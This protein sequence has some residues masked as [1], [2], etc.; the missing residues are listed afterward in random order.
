M[1]FS[2]QSILTLY[3]QLFEKKMKY[4]KRVNAN[5]EKCVKIL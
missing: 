4:E 1:G 2:E 5:Y 3:T